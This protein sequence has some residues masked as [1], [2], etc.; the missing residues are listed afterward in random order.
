[1]C[2]VDD[3]QWLDRASLQAFEFVA[4]RLFA[5]SVALVFGVRQPEGEQLLAGFAGADGRGSAQW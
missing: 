1:V 4:R 2:L 5:E 3:A